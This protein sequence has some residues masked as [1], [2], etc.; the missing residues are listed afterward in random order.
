MRGDH[1]QETLAVV[2]QLR[3]FSCFFFVCLWEVVTNER[4]GTKWRLDSISTVYY[5]YH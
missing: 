4:T 5:M 2:V 1:S 3:K